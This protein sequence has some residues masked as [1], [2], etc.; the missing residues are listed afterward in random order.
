MQNYTMMSSYTI[1]VATVALNKYD[2]DTSR[3]LYQF[4]RNVEYEFHA[5]C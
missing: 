4:P 3:F 1:L 5:V 2:F